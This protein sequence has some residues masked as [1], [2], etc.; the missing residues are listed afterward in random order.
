MERATIPLGSFASMRLFM[1]VLGVL[2]TIVTLVV[3]FGT[4]ALLS[5][6]F[7]FF[8]DGSRVQGVVGAAIVLGLGA[9]WV[10]PKVSP[11]IGWKHQPALVVESDF[12]TVRHPGLGEPLVVPRQLIQVASV[13]TTSRGLLAA[14]RRFRVS[15]GSPLATKRSVLSSRQVARLSLWGV[16]NVVVLFK[17][18]VATTPAGRAIRWGEHPMFRGGREVRGVA[19]HVNDP[20]RARAELARVEL[21]RAIRLED[22]A[23]SGVG[24]M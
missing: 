4:F 19:L 20:G 3:A 23:V 13:D 17:Q 10:G 2:A 21:L 1:I 8:S 9:M 15:S 12:L 16:P 7:P 18:P 22:L 5:A 24:A 11:W 14:H 6:G